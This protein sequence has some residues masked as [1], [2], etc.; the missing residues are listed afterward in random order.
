MR[1]LIL[2]TAI[3]AMMSAPVLAAMPAGSFALGFVDRDA[4]IGGRYQ[5]TDK[6]AGDAGFGFYIPDTGSKTYTVHLGLPIELLAHARCSFD[7]RPAITI[8]I[9]SPE[10]GDSSTDFTLHGWLMAN[11]MLTD[12]FGLNAG[13]GLNIYLVDSGNDT[14]TN[15]GTSGKNLTEIG[16]FYWF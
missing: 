14:V 9:T 4:P 2:V 13:H 8:D 5:I 3:V 1:K 11:V 12:N 7:F 6:I 10:V 16:W 15:F